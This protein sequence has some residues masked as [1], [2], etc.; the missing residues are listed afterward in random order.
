MGQILFLTFSPSALL[1]IHFRKLFFPFFAAIFLLPALLLSDYSICIFVHIPTSKSVY[2][3]TLDSH[4]IQTNCNLCLPVPEIPC[5][6]LLHLTSSMIKFNIWSCLFSLLLHSSCSG[7]SSC[8]SGIFFFFSKK[9][10]RDKETQAPAASLPPSSLSHTLSWPYHILILCSETSH[11]VLRQF[12]SSFLLSW[13]I[14]FF[15]PHPPPHLLCFIGFCK[16]RLS[17]ID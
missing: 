7:G 14:F 15:A 3:L 17:S 11:T 6:R 9:S 16:A 8:F 13:L 2:S 4:F 5:A 1:Y 10:L 12:S